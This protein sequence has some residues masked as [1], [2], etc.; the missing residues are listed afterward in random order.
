MS[1]ET[2]TP[3]RV[4][5][6]PIDAVRGTRDWLP[7]DFARLAELEALLLDRFAR[8]GYEPL[9]DAGAR[10]HRAA[11]A[12]ERRGDRGQAVRAGRR[13]RVRAAS[14]SVPS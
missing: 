4:A 6:R 1:D 10:A 9:R 5:E 3:R 7:G 2:P 8:A 14:A 13:A 11:R 12:Q